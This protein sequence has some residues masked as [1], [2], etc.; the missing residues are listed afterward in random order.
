MILELNSKMDGSIEGRPVQ[1]VKIN[2]ED[3]TF[4]LDEEALNDILKDEKIR[5]KPL[6]IVSVAGK[7]VN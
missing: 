1:V 4:M 6:C 3:H 5:D 7:R 2:D